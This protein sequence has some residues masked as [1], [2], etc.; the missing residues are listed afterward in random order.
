MM[1]MIRPVGTSKTLSFF[2]SLLISDWQMSSSYPHED[3]PLFIPEVHSAASFMK[4][5]LD[6]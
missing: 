3:L 6:C 5:L 4:R 2:N 1:N